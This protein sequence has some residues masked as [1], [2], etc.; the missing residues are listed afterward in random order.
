MIAYAKGARTFERHIDIDLDRQ[1][2]PYCSLP[3][4]IDIWFKAWK[5]V[6]EMCGAAGAAKRIPEARELAYLHKLLR[7]VYAKQDLP[8]GHVLTTDDVYLAIPLQAGQLSC[9]T[10]M[11]GEVLA[12][13]CGADEAVSIDM[14]ETPYSAAERQ[15]IRT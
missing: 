13:A 14:I 1:V 6:R 8:A 4:Q 2:S 9:R 15:G 3:H 5:K 7:G 12:R 11:T 10:F